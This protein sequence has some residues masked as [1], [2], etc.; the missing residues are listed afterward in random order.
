M[1]DVSRILGWLAVA[2]VAAS[3]PAARA[4][5]D[6]TPHLQ[7]ET[8]PPVFAY[9]QLDLQRPN[10]VRASLEG[11][12]VLTL[13]LVNYIR[14]H[15]LNSRDW[16]FTYDWS[17]LRKKLS[18]S[19][20]SFDTNN[21]DTNFIT[22]P[23]AGTLY[24]SA[25]RSNRMSVFESFLFAF[26]ASAIWEYFGEL[27]ERASL[28][29]LL[30]TPVAG[31]VLGENLLQL[32]LFF[33][34][35]CDSLA[36]RALGSV[37]GPFKSVHDALDSAE[38][39]RDVTCDRHGLSLRG[40][41]EFRLWVAAGAL[42][43]ARLETQLGVHSRIIALDS[44]GDPGIGL[45]T[46]AAGNVTELE[47]SGGW[48]GAS[49]ND[50]SLRAE[51][52]PFG[53]HYRALEPARSG[54][55]GYEV[56]F[57]VLVG[58]EYDLHRFVTQRGPALQDRFFAIDLPGAALRY[59]RSLGNA[60]LDLEL[61]ASVALAGVDAFALPVYLRS[62]SLDDLTSIARAHHYNYGAG[63]RVAPRARFVSEWVEVGAELASTVVAVINAQDRNQTQ[64]QVAGSERR[65]R[66]KLWLS[67]APH[68][69]NPW[70]LT[71]QAGLLHRAGSLAAAHAERTELALLAALE[72]VL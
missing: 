19:G 22:H 50:F 64:S 71:L 58:T 55:R 48:A 8:E 17:G 35:S 33:D 56:L 1:P 4:Q 3:A 54:L 60:H 5:P 36:N 51:V 41:H 6:L 27:R 32:G 28:N 70:R 63:F 11:I 49:W 31:L 59:R 72:A 24:Y 40:E 29:D 44:Y 47:L 23:F 18:G 7:V 53:L 67:V 37:F 20:Y 52:I 43:P 38:L 61:Q 13:E 2:C 65:T 39:L 62:N 68:A 57:G 21:F 69:L 42:V 45:R 30:S 9:R 10:Y 14:D 16:D 12:T 66:A 46:F 15:D 34:R 25:A 26:V